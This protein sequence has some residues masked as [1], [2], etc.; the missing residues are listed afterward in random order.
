MRQKA[1]SKMLPS[2]VHQKKNKGSLAQYVIDNSVPFFYCYYYLTA[3]VKVE[4]SPDQ[5]VPKPKWCVKPT[6]NKL[7]KE[8]LE[9]GI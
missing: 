3:L 5:I 7:P 4:D 1:V 2:M 6:T 9:G 8:W